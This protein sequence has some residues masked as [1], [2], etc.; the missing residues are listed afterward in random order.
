MDVVE[1]MLRFPG[2]D[3]MSEQFGQDD[4]FLEATDPQDS[5]IDDKSTEDDYKNTN[6]SYE[7]DIVSNRNVSN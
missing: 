4:S 5:F 3:D 7:E 1:K 2:E 6:T